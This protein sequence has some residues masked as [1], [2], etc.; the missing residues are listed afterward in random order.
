MKSAHF[1]RFCLPPQSTLFTTG[2][3]WH[4]A[5]NGQP[6][7]CING[8][9]VPLHMARVSCL[10]FG[11]LYGV[12]LFETFRTWKGRLF[13]FERHIE[14]LRRSICQLGWET[15]FCAEKLTEWVYETIR[16]NAISLEE[17]QDLRL[18]ITVT[19]GIVDFRRG[20]WE[21]DGDK[22]T[23]VIHAAPLP[24]GFDERHEHGLSAAIAP[25]R[26]QKDLPLWQFKS[27]SYFANVIAK[28][29]ALEN[30]F[31]EAIW[32]NSEGNL[33]EGTSTN[34]FLVFGGEIL[35]P[36]KEEGLLPGIGRQVAIELAEQLGMKVT[37][38]PVPMSLIESADEAFLTN[39]LIGVAPLLKLEHRQLPKMDIGKQLRKAY[40][41]HAVAAGVP[42]I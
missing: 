34:F 18:R 22:L 5:V 28:R 30:G 1:G 36:P 39:A 3:R 20:W 37:Q 10:D 40:L 2:V 29:W 27:S 35:T 11:F 32:V 25:W 38:K 21:F 31:Y 16:K 33:T 23:V 13:A 19:P 15:Q 14:R 4:I 26:R 24:I 7:L 17:G 12:G 42:V 8:E 41:E 6:I 9:F